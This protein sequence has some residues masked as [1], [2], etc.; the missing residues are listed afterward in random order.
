MQDKARVDT[1][2]QNYLLIEVLESI[3][4]RVDREIEENSKVIPKD[5]SKEQEL[6]VRKVNFENNI[7]VILEYINSL[8][9]GFM[10]FS[11]VELY[12]MFG[13]NDSF[14]TVKFHHN[15]ESAQK[16]GKEIM[17]VI[18]YNRRNRED[19]EKLLK[20]NPIPKN[21]GYVKF[22]LSDYPEPDIEKK[23]QL[24]RNGFLAS[25]VFEVG[26]IGGD[27]FKNEIK[28]TGKKDLPGYKVEVDLSDFKAYKAMINLYSRRIKDELYPLIDSEWNSYYAS[29]I[30][31]YRESIS[32]EEWESKIYEPGT[33][34]I[35]PDIRE[36]I[37]NIKEDEGQ[38]LSEQEIADLQSIYASRYKMNKALLQKEFRKAAP[39][40]KW[41]DILKDNWSIF[42]VL[43]Q[44]SVMFST[45][46]MST[47]GA[48]HSVYLDF[49]RYL[50]I[51]VRHCS[52]LQIEEFKQKETFKYK[53]T[54]VVK[55][56]R[57]L[58]G[59]VQSQIDKR[60]DEGIEFKA[61]DLRASYYDDEYYQIHIDKNGRLLSIYPYKK[62]YEE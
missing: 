49:E 50:H 37:Y 9:E 33:Q 13:K 2:N 59:Q 31:Y 26:S 38:K 36:V 30:F 41:N 45:I 22:E 11:V 32:K 28:D 14:L 29:R 56:M 23:E 52:E 43:W 34:T 39:R 12:A 51:M 15:S 7:K 1:M 46:N 6:L 61:H 57:S 62:P 10:A 35:R 17:G 8:K 40:K 3:I 54:D 55:L 21:D 27:F 18:S 16:Y 44:K 4:E 20:Q 60:L 53:L 5:E 19:L 47:F 58:I 25:D 42:R 24:L 48:K